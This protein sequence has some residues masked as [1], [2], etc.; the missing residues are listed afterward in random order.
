MEIGYV[1]GTYPT[2]LEDLVAKVYEASAPTVVIDSIV[3][4]EALADGTP[5]PGSG[6]LNM[7]TVTFTGL[8]NIPHILRL[9]SASGTQ[10]QEFNALPSENVVTLFDPISFKIGDGGAKTPAAGTNFYS[11]TDLA[12]LVYGDYLLFRNGALFYDYD[13]DPAGGFL[14]NIL[15][16]IFGDTEPFTIVRKPVAV[17]NYVNDSV[18]GKQWGP[19]TGNVDMFVDV[20][21][22]VGYL[23]THLRKLIRLSGSGVY[24]FNAAVPIGYPFRFSNQV[25]GS[26]TINFTTA[27]LITPAGDVTVYTLPTGTIA[28]FVFDG[29][30]FNKTF[31]SKTMLPTYSTT[32]QGSL[33]LGNIGAPPFNVTSYDSV[34]TITI[35]D[36]LTTGYKVRGVLVSQS[37]NI[38]VDNDVSFV[39]RILSATQFKLAVRKYATAATNL[40]FDFSIEKQN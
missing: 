34:F 18:V 6:H 14:L 39:V 37:A 8:D 33:A 3:I 2:L 30:K 27:P 1:L 10:F 21:S 5:S 7:P 25:G 35:P 31:E 26:G 12:G 15:G 16:D 9:F 40:L 13:N 20:V 19:T 24:N 23:E 38:D 36:Q 32:Y 29:T 28:E 17:T 22:T 4:P 11:N